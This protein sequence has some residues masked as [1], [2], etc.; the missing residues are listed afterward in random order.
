MS[1]LSSGLCLLALAVAPTAAAAEPR[2][3]PAGADR[4]VEGERPP[5]SLAGRVASFKALAYDDPAKPMFDGLVH[6]AEIGDGIEFGMGPEGVQNNLD[7]VPAFVDVSASRIEV[8]FERAAQ[9]GL[10]VDTS[11]NGYLL[12]FE[13]DC[14][15]ID[16]ASVDTQWSTMTLDPDDLIFEGRTL[17]INLAGRYYDQTSRIAID[18]SVDDCPMS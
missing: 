4:V 15:V 8:S 12:A 3:A 14:L 9:P 13:P 2:I 5:A 11:F 10:M 6:T 18:L 17:R 7:V 16:K 1:R